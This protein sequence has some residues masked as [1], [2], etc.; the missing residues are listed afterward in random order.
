MSVVTVLTM[1]VLRAFP[2]IVTVFYRTASII[3]GAIIVM[4]FEGQDPRQWRARLAWLVPVMILPYLVSVLFVSDLLTPHWRTIPQALAALDEFGL[5]PLYHHYIVSK[6]HAAESVVVHVLI[7]APVG[8]MIALRRGGGRMAE[9]T[10]AIIAGLLSL[11]IEIGRW[12]K[13]DLQPDFSNAII[14]AVA[15][16][17]AVRFT[18]VF[19][20]ML[21]GA[22]I[23]GRPTT[24]DM[25]T[26]RDDARSRPIEVGSC[27]ND[28]SRLRA[29]WVGLAVA[30]VCFPLGAAITANYSL[31]AWLLGVLLALYG[32]ALW[33][34]PSLWLAVIPAVLPALDLTPWTGWMY[35]GEPGLFVLVT[36]GILA[37]RSPPRRVDFAVEGL[38]AVA[39]ALALLAYLTGIVLGLSFPGPVGG[40]DNPY[41]R[42][43][44]ALR[45]AKGFFVALALLPFLRERMRRTA[46]ATAWLGAG[47]SAGLAL[48][49]AA[50]IVE[51]A[52]VT[53]LFDF[54][55]HYRVVG[56]F[57]SMH[58]G[59]G[60]IG[61]YLA[62]ACRFC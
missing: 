26:A 29:T 11:A 9:W 57:S 17:L 25:V 2:S 13:P 24:N 61:A 37:L 60:H 51:R 33:R 21:E 54:T 5:L 49:V 1:L 55:S 58:V 42:P 46:N 18:D 22:P 32:M 41:L 16:G 48:V 10:A 28:Q 35:V 30:A 3:A 38:P 20:R 36:I 45:L 15:A 8:V 34:W 52:L 14:A 4:W 39:L 19:W 62:M 47:M 53:S 31:G 12:F 56:T 43:D 50:A 40:S 23:V 27:N 44:N 7:F 59:A 6:A